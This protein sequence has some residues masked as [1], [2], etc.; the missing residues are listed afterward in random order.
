MFAILI[1]VVASRGLTY[2]QTYQTGHFKYVQMYVNKA[3]PLKR[4]ATKMQKH[5]EFMKP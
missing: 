5:A 3:I 1:V 4:A 2:V